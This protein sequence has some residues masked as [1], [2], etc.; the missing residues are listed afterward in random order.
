MYDRALALLVKRPPPPLRPYVADTTATTRYVP[1]TEPYRHLQ[2]HDFPAYV[3]RLA[4][5]FVFRKRG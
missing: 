3:E 1:P 2:A 5:V 4:A